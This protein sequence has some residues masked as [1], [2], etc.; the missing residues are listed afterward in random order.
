M[1]M[2]SIRSNQFVMA[3]Y[4]PG[5]ISRQP[6]HKILSQL[7]APLGLAKLLR[8]ANRLLLLEAYDQNVSQYG[9]NLDEIFFLKS[10]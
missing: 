9:R 10:I 5:T 7:E 1:Q 2:A 3:L 8:L 4:S 6:H